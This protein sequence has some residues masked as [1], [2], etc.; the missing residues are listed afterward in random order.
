[1]D[2]P[3]LQARVRLMGG[4]LLPEGAVDAVIGRPFDEARPL[5]RRAGAENLVQAE[6]RGV[7]RSME[8][9]RLTLVLADILILSR[10]LRGRQRE[11]LLYWTHNLELANLKA[12]VHGR[13]AGLPASRIREQLLDMGPLATLPIE[14]L[15]RADSALE[16]LR[17]LERTPFAEIAG[18]ARRVIEE[19]NDLFYLDTSFDRRFFGGLVAR[20]HRTPTGDDARFRALLGSIIDRI[21]LTWLLRYRFAYGLTPA[22]TYYLLIPSAFL[23]TGSRLRRLASQDH[24]EEVL[25][26]LPRPLA[27]RLEGASSV[28][29]VQDR[30]E[31]HT[32]E[33][34]RDAYVRSGSAFVRAFAYITLR[35]QDLWLLRGLARARMLE[36][37][38][39][40][41]REGLRLDRHDAETARRA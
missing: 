8:Q 41:T 29:Q 6:A 19:R 12:I 15:M 35:G 34:A 9:R 17:R 2:H 13:V 36:V 26:Q 39:A 16:V 33:L 28:E 38:P 31:R 20:A 22:E 40:L 7:P 25:A 18:Q 1:M 3:Y 10:A 27:T 24:F 14:D 4:R 32:R 23:L 21:N 11:F 5:Y 30:L 37:D